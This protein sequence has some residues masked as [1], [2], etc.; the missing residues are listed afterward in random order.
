MT[1]SPFLILLLALGCSLIIFALPLDH[2]RRQRRYFKEVAFAHFASDWSK[3]TRSARVIFLVN[4]HTAIRIETQLG[5]V[6]ALDIAFCSDDDGRNHVALFN[7]AIGICFFN[8][9]DDN[10]AYM[11]RSDVL[12]PPSTLMHLTRFAPELSATFSWVSC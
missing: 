10:I 3:N 6:F 1:L 9:A 2:F 4:Q 5:P 11:R 7:L 12:V 8:R